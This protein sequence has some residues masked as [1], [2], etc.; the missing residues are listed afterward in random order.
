MI[1]NKALVNF[2]QQKILVNSASI[3]VKDV[4]E[5]TSAALYYTSDKGHTFQR[6]WQKS[7]ASINTEKDESV[8][9]ATLPESATAWFFNIDVNGLIYSSKFSERLPKLNNI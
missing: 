2:N 9:T 4:N 1:N 5:I 3:H 6:E 8:L 7:S